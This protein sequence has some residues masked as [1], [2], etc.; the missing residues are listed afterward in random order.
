MRRRGPLLLVATMGAALALADCAGTPGATSTET[1]G[2]A[3]SNPPATATPSAT[4]TADPIA[5][6]T[7]EQEVGQLFVVGTDATRA[8]PAT[9]ALVRDRGVGGI[10]LGGRST[11]G[12]DATASVVRAFTDLDTTAPLIVATDQEGGEVQVLRGSGFDVIPSAADQGTE[13]PDALASDAAIWGRELADAG[14]NVDLA[15]VADV[16]AAGTPN[17]PIGD[18]A[19]SYGTTADA[20]QQHA[21]AVGGALRQAGVVPTYKHFPG[22]GAVGANTDTTAHVT[23]TTITADSD[24]VAAFATLAEQGPSF[25]MVSSAVYARID[26]S[27]PAVFSYDVV[28]GLLRDRLGFDGLVITDDLSLARQV[29]AWSPAR[30]AVLAIDAGCNLVLASHRP[31]IA[32]SMIDGVIAQAQSDPQFRQRVDDAARHV[33]EQKRTL[34]L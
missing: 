28:T 26:A 29:T 4:P 20:V 24:Q 8:D 22:L 10:F 11:A 33:L 34:G 14:V 21:G 19:R 9:I 12:V 23:D 25:V 7:L 2:A 6:L 13:S 27:T 3:S 30:R 17:P 31:D 15:P 16:V 18:L 5:G 32:A 1:R